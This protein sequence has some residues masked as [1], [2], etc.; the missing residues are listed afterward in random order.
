MALARIDSSKP[1]DSVKPEDRFAGRARIVPPRSVGAGRLSLQDSGMGG[2]LVTPG[3][4][5]RN[6]PLIGHPLD[7]SQPNWSSSWTSYWRISVRE[8]RSRHGAAPFLRGRGMLDGG[9]KIFGA[10]H[11]FRL[12]SQ[13]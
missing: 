6:G 11:G 13:A 3:K 7:R 8:P 5:F 12:P 4:S 1:P 9:A 10:V 2:S